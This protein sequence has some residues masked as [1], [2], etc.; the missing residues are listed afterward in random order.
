[1]TDVIVNVP[2]LFTA[3]AE[4]VICLLHILFL[5]KRFGGVKRVLYIVAGLIL[6]VAYQY[7]AGLLPLY[8]WIP[9]IIGAYAL[10]FLFI[11]FVCDIPVLSAGYWSIQAF[12]IAEFAASLEWQ[13]YYFFL[14]NFGSVAFFST[15]LFETLFCMF[16]YLI[17]FVLLFFLESRYMRNKTVLDVRRRDI[18]S[19][20]GIVLIVFVVSN[21]S[22]IDIDTPF[23]GRYELEIFYIRTLVDLCGVIL[24]YTHR[25]QKLW[26]HAKAEIG[27]LQ[28]VLNR[29]YEQY[30]ASKENIE[31]L[32]RKYH[33]LKHQIAVIRAEPNSK[34]RSEY[35]EQMEKGIKM[36]ETQYQTGNHVLDIVL[37]SKSITCVEHNINFTCV[38]D[39]S[40][41]K[42]MEVM[43]ICSI[44]GNALDNAIENVKNIADPQKRLIKLAVYSQNDLLLISLGNYYESVL[45]YDN[46]DLITTKGDNF[47]HG[48]GIKSIKITAAKYNGTVTISTDNNWFGL[49]VLIPLIKRISAADMDK[50]QEK[51]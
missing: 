45:K 39:G 14:T 27:A 21:L 30:C 49:S 23:T 13:L 3:V 22:F 10:M 51:Q 42:F 43:D 33:D 11:Y 12:I 1:M 8:L 16:I 46:G 28:N 5:K 4:W 31:L 36:Y 19:V 48:Y 26:M 6:Q 7:I 41:L 9:G 35:L 32:N 40:L 44:F 25:E 34:K 37:T 15:N 47:N 38:A 24:L 29:Q 2:R 50:P 18:L 17:I 20:S